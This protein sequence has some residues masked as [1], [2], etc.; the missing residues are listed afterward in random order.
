[1]L[2]PS[3]TEVKELRLTVGQTSELRTACWRLLVHAVPPLLLWASTPLRTHRTNQVS[4]R[5]WH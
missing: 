4:C 1:M 2:H 3:T 5:R